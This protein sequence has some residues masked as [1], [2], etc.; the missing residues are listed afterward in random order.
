MPDQTLDEIRIV[1]ENNKARLYEKRK[2][3]KDQLEKLL[4]QF[5]SDDLIDLIMKIQEENN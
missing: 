5:S 4:T 2:A 1:Q 3:A